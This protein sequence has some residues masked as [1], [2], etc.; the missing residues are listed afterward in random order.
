[1]KTKQ[2]SICG[3]EK[4]L[5]NFEY[6]NRENRSYCKDCNNAEMRIRN[7]DGKEGAAK[8]RAEMRKSWRT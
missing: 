2:C 1:M 8:W 3:N 6:G 5:K 4:A 7:R